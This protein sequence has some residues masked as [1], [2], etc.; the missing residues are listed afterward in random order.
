MR[1]PAAFFD[2]KDRVLDLGGWFKPEPKAT[3]VVDFMPWETRGAKVNLDPLPGERFSRETWHQADFLD[4]NFVLPFPDK[5]FEV[6]ICGHTIEDL[7][8][9]GRLLQEIQRVGLGGVIECPSRLT[10]QTLGARDRMARLSGHPHHHWIVDSE[11]G[12]LVLCSKE[13]SRLSSASRLIPLTYFENFRKAHPNADL[14]IHHWSEPL[15]FRFADPA[16]CAR[17]AEQFVQRQNIT[18]TE[19]WRDRALRLARR[20]RAGLRGNAQ[21]DFSWWKDILEKSR[22]YSRISLG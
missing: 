5:S 17:R 11:D 7:A 9:P 10:E 6:V 8:S 13:E 19:R 12:E 20:T 1:L 14:V 4:P 15:R 18:A 3:H 2:G 16:E 21:E 22:P